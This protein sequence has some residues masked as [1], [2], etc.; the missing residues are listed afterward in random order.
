M[1]D[2]PSHVLGPAPPL[3]L[4]ATAVDEGGEGNAGAGHQGP[5]PLGPT[6]LVGADGHQVDR[7]ALLSRIEPGDDLD[8]VGVHDGVGRP[9]VHQAGH[10]VQGLDRPDLVVDPHHAHQADLRRARLGQLIE[11]HHAAGSLRTSR[12]STP[13]CLA[14]SPAGVQD[15][16]VLHGGAH[17]RT[18]WP[19]AGGPGPEHG[20]VVGLGTTLV[21]T[22]SPG[23]TARA[24]ARASR[25]SSSAMRASRAVP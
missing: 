15:G 10:L 2:D 6:E 4:L 7:S 20:Q 16:R 8:G 17:D 22:T 11:V 23:S 21:N 13:N 19:V 14:C 25:A 18:D 12:S 1:A 3:S 5:H 24:V 9:F